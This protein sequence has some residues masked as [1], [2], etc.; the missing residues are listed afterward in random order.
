M[1]DHH[2]FVSHSSK[3]DAIVKALRTALE[4]L[5]LGVWAD[6]RRL[7]GGDALGPTI[8]AAIEAA[9]HFIVVL[10]INALN[11]PWVREEIRHALAVQKGRTDGFKVIPLLLDP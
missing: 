4:G 3:D 8:R 10:S 9:R 1:S 7:T 5:G 6:S 2:V 11:S